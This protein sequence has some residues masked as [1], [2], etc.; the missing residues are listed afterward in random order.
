MLWP[1]VRCQDLGNDGPLGRRLQRDSLKRIDATKLDVE[2]RISQ[3]F[4][5]VG[6]ALDYL[7][8]SIEM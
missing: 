1:G 6:E 7:S 4:N 5:C 3:V 2:A 8:L